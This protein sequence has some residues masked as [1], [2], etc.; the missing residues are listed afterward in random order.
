MA[1]RRRRDGDGAYRQQRKCCV[2]ATL[3]RPF[4]HIPCARVYPI[5]HLRR[6]FA[7]SKR[8]G[9]CP[10]TATGQPPFTVLL[11]DP[12]DIGRSG[13]IKL[14]EEDVRFKILEQTATDGPSSARRLQS[15][16]DLIVIDPDS[17]QRHDL[18]LIAELREAAPAA[19]IAI[20]TDLFEERSFLAATRAGARVYLIKATTK[21]E[22][23]G[24]A[25][26]LLARHSAGVIDPAIV[27]R[28]QAYPP[29]AL[30]L[31]VPD[32][33]APTLTERERQMLR[34]LADGLTH[35][36]I[37]GRGYLTVK[38][39]DRDIARLHVKLNVRT[40]FELGMKAHALG[41]VP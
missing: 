37:A 36:E 32:P 23:L 30:T 14:L 27:D 20:V 16:L 22:L 2:D 9:G 13:L 41:L 11:I 5:R 33:A 12:S 10:V 31:R 19:R 18:A 38:M 28:F 40:P 24:D 8:G 7:F 21:G 1:V 34:G 17:R 15:K 39:V 35:K 29:N 25:L 4:T 26:A 3:N 6:N